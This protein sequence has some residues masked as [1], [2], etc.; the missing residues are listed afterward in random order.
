[1]IMITRG[2]AIAVGRARRLF[3]IAPLRKI[4][5]PR[6]RSFNTLSNGVSHIQIDAAVSEIQS[7]E[8]GEE[9]HWNRCKKRKQTSI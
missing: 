3:I 4:N 9:V 2:T 7:L 5:L 1:M 8:H 6:I